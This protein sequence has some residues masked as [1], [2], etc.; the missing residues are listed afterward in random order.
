MCR[1]VMEALSEIGSRISAAEHKLIFLDLDGSFLPPVLDPGPDS[2]WERFKRVLTSLVDRRDTSLAVMSGLDRGELHDRLGIA[3]MHYLG[4]HGLEISGPGHIFVEPTATEK[5]TLLKDLGT[6]LTA[7]LQGIAGVTVEDKGLSLSVS[8]SQVA[9]EN[10][11][12]LRRTVH[13][14][15]AASDH[16]FQLTSGDNAFE[17]RP[18]VNWNKGAAVSWVKEQ[19]GHPDA[20]V[21]YV[22]DNLS[23][24]NPGASLPDAIAIKVGAADPVAQFKVDGPIEVVDFLQWL[25][26]FLRAQERGLTDERQRY[27]MV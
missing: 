6:K 12:Q 26:D 7:K 5:T 24:E 10:L 23:G 14:A 4:N 25:D 13:A 9:G 21:I 17:I 8:Y 2:L 27:S 16:P 20:L 19:I 3:G 11:E 18:R 22:D 1:N 15:L